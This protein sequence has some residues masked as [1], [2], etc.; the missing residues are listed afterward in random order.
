ME[1]P[2]VTNQPHL[3]FFINLEVASKRRTES[4]VTE[5]LPYVF[6]TITPHKDATATYAHLRKEIS[7]ATIFSDVNGSGRLHEFGN[8]K[9]RVSVAND[10]G[11]AAS[12]TSTSLFRD[13]QESN[14]KNQ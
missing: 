6:F 2:K 12:L 7:F 4:R 9:A 1:L 5:N 14:G 11:V 8:H 10:H 13:A 3:Y